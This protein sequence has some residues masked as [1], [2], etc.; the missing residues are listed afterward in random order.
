MTI[1]YD[2]IELFF[3]LFSFISVKLKEFAEK[4]NANNFADFSRFF[5]KS[6]NI[7]FFYKKNTENP[8]K[9]SFFLIKGQCGM[10]WMKRKKITKTEWKKFYS[11]NYVFKVLAVPKNAQWRRR[12]D[13]DVIMFQL[14]SKLFVPSIVV[15]LWNGS[16]VIARGPTNLPPSPGNLQKAQ[17]R[18]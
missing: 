3:V 6:G 4:T 1:R 16:W 7:G 12:T 5:Q 13:N 9:R 15:I 14:G 2:W 17:P 10:K 8:E 11:I 18:Y